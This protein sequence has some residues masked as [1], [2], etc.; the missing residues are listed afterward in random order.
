M[1]R[2]KAVPERL[3]GL[4]VEVAIAVEGE[5]DRGMPGPR[6]DLLG[7]RPGRNPQRDRRMPQVVD[8]QPIKAGLRPA[9]P[10]LLLGKNL[11]GWRGLSDPETHF[12]DLGVGFYDT[13]IGPERAKRN[14]SAS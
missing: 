7:I 6:G 10:R 1:Q 11:G 5:A 2:I 12:H 14:H 4:G 9:A 3:I 8:A 13:R